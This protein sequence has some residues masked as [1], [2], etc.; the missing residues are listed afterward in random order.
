M[1]QLIHTHVHMDH[2]GQGVL[3]PAAKIMI[4]RNGGGSF[5]GA[6]PPATRTCF[7]RAHKVSVAKLL[8]W[9]TLICL[10][11]LLAGETL[12]LQQ[13]IENAEANNRAIRSAEIE[14]AKALDEIN[15][16]RTYRLPVFSLTAL[17]SQSLAR[18]GLTF[19]QG[20]LGVYPNVGPIPGKTTTLAGPLQP[21]GILYAS[22]A[23]PLSQQHKVGLGIQLARVGVDTA[24][25]SIRSKR[26]LT[27]NEVRRLYYGIL[28]SESARKSLQATV[29]FLRQ[30][31]ADTGRNVSQR[32]AL[33]A[34]S[35]DVKAQLVQTEYALLKLEDPLQTQKQ[36]LNR[37]M[38]RDPDTPFD[39]DPLSA[40]DFEM[41]DLKQA[42]AR[43]IESRPEVRLAKLQEKKAMLDER[44]KSAERIPDVSLTMT[45]VATAN[46]SPVLPNRLSVVGIQVNWDVYDWGR[47]RNQVEEKQL[48]AEQASLDAKDTEAKIIVEV[49][50]QYRKLIEA[51][52]QIEVAL[53]SQSASRE[54]LRV[55]RNRFGQNDVL[56]SD[57]LKVQSSLA[58]ADNRFAQALLDLATAQADFE[59][60]LGEDQ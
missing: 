51:R 21:G 2:A 34:D 37:L 17:G 40:A 22:V 27:L 1:G 52:K 12:T 25:E 3:L 4:Q 58:E 30:I 16:A 47:K 28:Q 8:I 57:L 13:A 19:P 49:A 59:K 44:L 60:A 31:D 10:P 11:E 36:Q 41:P 53:A 32:V 56:L 23:Q 29:D 38:G 26:Q 5:A 33:R 45:S 18:L 43:A 54:L 35:L 14:R 6:F 9:S 39:V 7:L 42:Y 20:S 50:H 55:T 15:V 46:L 24:D 48:A